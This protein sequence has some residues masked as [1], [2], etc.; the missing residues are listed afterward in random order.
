MHSMAFGAENSN[1]EFSWQTQLL[2]WLHC[3]LS[4]FGGGGG[5]GCYEPGA[6]MDQAIRDVH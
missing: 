4:D 2:S 5:D 1:F 3:D 6:G